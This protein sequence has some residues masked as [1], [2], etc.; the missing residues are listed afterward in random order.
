MEYVDLDKA[1]YELS[2]MVSEWVKRSG[3]RC[4]YHKLPHINIERPPHTGM[5]VS[6]VCLSKPIPVNSEKGYAIKK[7]V[8]LS[9]VKRISLFSDT[10]KKLLY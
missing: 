8:F 2:Q 4:S 7:N 6:C 9:V 5:N 3:L 10:K 1:E